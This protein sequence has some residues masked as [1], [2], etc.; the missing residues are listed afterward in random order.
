MREG[1][2]GELNKSFGID[3][4]RCAFTASGFTC[5]NFHAALKHSPLSFTAQPLGFFAMI[6]AQPSDGFS[7]RA[8]RRFR[9]GV[10][11]KGNAMGRYLGT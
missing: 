3:G 1:S 2:L 7:T 10:S 4:L 5:K 9:S 6:S 8:T 11:L